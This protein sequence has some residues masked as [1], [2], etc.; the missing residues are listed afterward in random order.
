[1]KVGPDFAK[2]K[3]SP[4]PAWLRADFDEFRSQLPV[5][6]DWWKQ[7]NDPA[8]D[9]VMELARQQNLTI[10]AA[11]VRILAARAQLGIAV[12][13][14]YPQTQELTGGYTFTDASKSGPSA[15]QPKQQA[16]AQFQY[17]Q[18]NAGFS[19]A[20]EL[21][22]WGKYR[23]DIESAGA[24][25]AATVA[26]YDNAL[27]TL[28]G[29]TASAYATLRTSQERLRIARENVVLQGEA[30]N[31][32]TIR[33]Q[34]GAT[35]E[36]DV[37]QAKTQLEA[38]M[39][40]VPK[41]ENLIAKAKNALSVLLGKEPS[42]LSEILGE[43]MAI[44][45]C[46]DA[47]GVGLPADMLRRRPDVRQA[48]FSAWAQCARIGVAKADLFPSFSLS[49]NVGWLSSNMG[50][51]SLASLFTP[52]SFTAGFSPTITWPIF[53]YGRIIN[54]VR[55]QDAR[56]QESL[57]TYSNTVLKALKE[58]EDGLSDYRQSRLRTETL[59]KAAASAKRGAELAFLQYRE[60]KTDFTTVIVAQQEQLTEQDSLA[61]SQGD[62]VLGFVSLHRAL[63]SAWKDRPEPV[64]AAVKEQMKKRTWWGRE[65]DESPARQEDP[66]KAGPGR[67]LPDF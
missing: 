63:G 53:N 36:R 32:A 4:P 14:F 56:F 67:Y 27:V 31:I 46:P 48:E 23:R 17:W 37:M 44:P 40:T 15:P 21:D 11:G 25:L 6:G 30:L 38:T 58:T 45:V 18:N 12:G 3:D 24:T 50:A 20:W 62:I 59:A 60:G 26:D 16:G 33:F 7:L 65:I 64:P 41:L 54:N 2:P 42:D 22:F 61:Q 43:K 28:A 29:D 55:L 1:M 5:A 49:G 57:I 51:F 13:N 8:L 52:Q 66:D 9:R 19:A 34:L 10:Q 39:A 35:S 47:T